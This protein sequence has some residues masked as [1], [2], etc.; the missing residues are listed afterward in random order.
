VLAVVE[1]DQPWRGAQARG[2]HAS[3]VGAVRVGS[4]CGGEGVLDG[5]SRGGRRERREAGMDPGGRR[6][7]LGDGD[8]DPGLADTAHADERHQPSLREVS[9]DL[10]DQGVAAHEGGQVGR[11]RPA[12]LT[13]GGRGE[14][15]A[16]HV[17][18]QPGE[19]RRGVEPEL[20]GE[21]APRVPE[22][23]QRLGLASGPVQ[24]RRQ[25]PP[26]VLA[27]R[28]LG[29]Q[30]TRRLD[31]RWAVE[32]VEQELRRVQPGARQRRQ[33]HLGSVERGVCRRY[34]VAPQA[35]GLGEGRTGGGRVPVRAVKKVVPVPQVDVG[36]QPMP[37]G[38][39]PDRLPAEHRP[40]P[41][42]V[43]GERAPGRRRCRR[44]P[45]QVRQAIRARPVRPGEDE[46]RNHA[47]L[48]R[49]AQ[50]RFPALGHDTDRPEDAHVHERLPRS[51]DP[52]TAD[53]MAA[54]AV[55][56][57]TVRAATELRE[58]T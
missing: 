11:R 8:R 46:R 24:R 55:A 1:H 49:P 28:V 42:E 10:L 34:R 20:L 15:V 31:R 33:L 25:R 52:T 17:L 2:E 48:A 13:T 37:P 35:E 54:P 39:A 12:G 27:V 32:V 53:S 21:D 50:G 57:R 45:D 7:R 41:G 19:R 16:E 30:R 6:H 23:G 44:A 22:R 36:H 40:H 38:L 3:D 9:S 5:P 43:G 14:V 4:H 26:R 47:P 51:D 29:Q 18:L 56:R 58:D